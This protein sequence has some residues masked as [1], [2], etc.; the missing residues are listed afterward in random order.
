LNEGLQDGDANVHHWAWGVI[1]GYE[2]GVDGITI[3]SLREYSQI[4]VGFLT[5]N[6]DKS[7]IALGNAG[8]VMGNAFNEY[9]FGD[10]PGWFGFLY[11]FEPEDYYFGYVP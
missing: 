4:E 11:N 6:R 3:N 2:L 9:G 7:D 8:I 1:L 10:I 5:V